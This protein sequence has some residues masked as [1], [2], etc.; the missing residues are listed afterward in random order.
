[1]ID[2]GGLWHIKRNHIAIN[3]CAIKYVFREV[4]NMLVKPLPLSKAEMVQKVINDDVQF[5]WFFVT[6]DFEIDDHVI[7][8]IL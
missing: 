2:R 3:F 5:Y 4:L 1:L 6:F 8:E 7:H